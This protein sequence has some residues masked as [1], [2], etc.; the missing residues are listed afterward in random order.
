LDETDT[1]GNVQL[2]FVGYQGRIFVYQPGASAIQLLTR[3]PEL[4]LVPQSTKRGIAVGGVIDYRRPHTINHVITGMLGE[5]EVVVAG[6]D[7]GD[8]VAYDV[9]D[10][11]AEVLRIGKLRSIAA[12]KGSASPSQPRSTTKPF[13]HE[14]VGKSA[15]GLAV[16]RQSRL[17]AV[18]SNHREIT[19]FAVALHGDHVG[20]ATCEGCTHVKKQ[21][22]QRRRTWQIVI[23]LGQGADNIPNVSF[24]ED[25][26]GEADKVC[27]MDISGKAWIADIW[28]PRE[29]CS[30]LRA[31]PSSASPAFGNE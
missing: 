3:C 8:V 11:L 7:N 2:Y 9:R 5:R 14:N 19:V 26:H 28:N 27:G 20:P 10:V 12:R 24:L 18:S 22:Q 25:E 15:W 4:Q 1:S 16:H 29:Q 31:S 30:Y 13:L 6:Y 21:V 17:I 23:A